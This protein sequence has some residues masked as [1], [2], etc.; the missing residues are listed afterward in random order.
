MNIYLDSRDLIGVLRDG[1]PVDVD[2]LEQVLVAKG[3]RL[4]Y[5]WPIWEVAK[6]DDLLESR[7]RLQALEHMP[8]IY[9]LGMPH[10]LREE[11]LNAISAFR[12]GDHEVAPVRPW[13]DSW[14][15]LAKRR[16]QYDYQDMLVH[17]TLSDQILEVM[18]Q[19]PEVLQNREDSLRA[20]MHE[21]Q[22][23]RGASRAERRSWRRFSN[24]VRIGL[25]AC[26]LPFPNDQEGGLEF[27]EWLD[28]TP[29]ACPAYK[30]FNDTYLEF[31]DNVRDEGDVGDESDYTHIT[32]VTYVDAITLDRR[33]RGY[34]VAA[35]RR[36]YNSGRVCEDYSKRIFR[37]LAEWLGA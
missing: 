11:F 10:L 4:V 25:R 7:R 16:G 34:C 8:H 3:A 5:Y 14:H 29:S 13:E 15:R 32:A 31:C 30:L 22:A 19:R 23:D 35:A 28:K 33:M 17:N 1:R 20:F 21:V 18:M 36:L 26:E 27:A 6:R 37:D 9:L 2:G 12:N 24:G